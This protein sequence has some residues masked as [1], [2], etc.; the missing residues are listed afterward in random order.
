VKTLSAWPF[1]AE[2]GQLRDFV[3]THIWTAAGG[4]HIVVMGKDGYHAVR[5]MRLRT[6][7]K[8]GGQPRHDDGFTRQG[9]TLAVLTDDYLEHLRVINRTPD[10]V[11]NRYNELKPFLSW[12]EERDL[13]EPER[14]TR[15]IL[16]SYQRWLWGYRKKNGKPLGIST[17][18]G[19][20]GAVIGFF[21]WLCKHHILEANPASEI[22]MPRAEKRLPVEALSLKEVEAVLS[23]PNIGDRLGIRDRAILELF[24]STGIRR[25]ELA[26][27][28]VG[29]LNREKRLLHVRHGKGRKDRV[30]PVGSRALGWIEKYLDDVRPLLMVKPEE[31]GL[32]LSGYGEP[33]SPDVLGRKVVEYIVQ[34]EIGRKGGAHL[35][36]HTCATH[37]LEGGA[38]IRYIQQ[39]L[40]HEKLE[41]TAIYTEVSVIQLQVVHARCH[42]A[43]K[44]RTWGRDANE[45]DPAHQDAQGRAIGAG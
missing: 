33:F 19:Y 42:P 38:D 20:L 18:R 6:H 1:A 34:A 25:S 4:R 43:E 41:T 10:A 27:L 17:Q 40:G 5:W 44:S 37:L 23:Q 35:L 28:E 8:R 31:Q 2:N 14:I 36:R 16:E 12:A 22:E 26:R 32:F 7:E 11:G 21:A 30:V 29:D 24:Y 15:T 39:L 3:G 13:L 45:P 9:L